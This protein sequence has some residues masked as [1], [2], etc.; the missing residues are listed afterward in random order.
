[1][2]HRTPALPLLAALMTSL[3]VGA[4]SAA[5]PDLFADRVAPLLRR[6]AS[7]HNAEKKRGGLDLTTRD[8]LLA[9]GDTGP[10]AKPGAADNSLLIWMVGGPEAKMPKQ[11]PKLT[12]D[13]FA[14]LRRW[15]DAGA[16]WPKDVAVTAD[17]PAADGEEWWSLRPV[18]RPAVPAVKDVAW[19]RNPIDAFLL[20]AMEQKGLRPS[21]P[22]DKTTLIRR[23]TFDLIG[24]PPTPEEI[25]VFL[26]DDSP[27]AYEKVVDR[28]LASP[29]YGERWARHWLDV[30]HYADTH[31][32]DK[33]KRRDH[34]WPYRDYVIR[35]FND[36]MPYKRFIQEQLAGDVLF[37]GDPDGVTATGFV[38]AGPWDFVG[39]VE[40]REGTVDKEKTRV[41][42]R[43]DMVINAVS[44]FDSMTV[45]CARCHDHKF[46]PIP[47]KD[48]YRL[49][50]VFAGVERGDRP[51]L[52]KD[53]LA[54]RTEL[55]ARRKQIADER[56]GF[57]KK[58]AD[59]SSPDLTRLDGE[60]KKAREDLAALPLPADAPSPTNGWHSGIEAKPDAVKWVQVD[61]GKSVAIDAVRLIPARPTD[62]PDTPGFGFPVRF[63][64]DASDDPSF[65]TAVGVAD[66]MKEDYA[67]PGDDPV[68][69]R[70]AALKARFVR[71]TATR[72]WKRTG[73]Y[74]F[75]LAELEVDSG[76]KN[77]A[78]V[79]TVTS[80]DS[81]E[82]GRWGRRNLVDGYDSRAA[83]PDFSD[84]KTP[85]ALKRR[86]ELQERIQR[87]EK[88]RQAA[89]EALLDAA[90]RDGLART[91]ADLAA[92]DRDLA[93]LAKT[94]LVYAVAPIP[95]RPIFVLHRGDVEQKREQVT[96]GALSCV[97]E[98][99][100]DFKDVKENDEGSRRAALARWVADNRNPLT[101]RSIV[102][103]VWHYHFGRGIVDTPSDLGRNGS[104][105]T[106]PELLD[107]LA[108]EFRDGGGSFK[109]LHRLIVTSAAY[110]QSSADNPEA[111]KIDADDR[112]LWRMTRQRLDAEEVRDSVLA[113]SGKLDLT[114]GGPGFELF[115]FKDD[116]SPV[117]D[118]TAVENIND[119]ANWRR[120]VYRFT[121]RSVPNPFLESLDCADPNINTPVRNTTLTALQALALLNDP[122][123]LKQADCFAERLQKISDDPARQAEAA[124]RLA[125]GRPPTAEERDALVDYAKKHGLAKACRVLFNANEFVF[126]D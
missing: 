30:A 61:L 89:I 117:Y 79:A 93:E 7:C 123:A 2:P 109:K 126:I 120:T 99:D 17:K 34:A 58:A 12:A 103:R 53:A 57:L 83:L 38:V 85:E 54:R 106:H 69:F 60:L 104:R 9:G 22:A 46:D 28:L 47:Q 27:D 119:P 39:H 43:D 24:L 96:P 41:L 94:N 81:I 13:E 78:R 100:A 55:E 118:H 116:H 5:E 108:V 33:D 101:W 23:V 97:K 105:P 32:Y 80:L 35:A 73:D 112:F 74:V 107:W 86:A 113:V 125:F 3:G 37:P 77:A 44:T 45:H 36:D 121:V 6:C 110:R 90:T 63:R 114:M 70:P 87:V 111:A 51:Y 64:V 11:G 20:A 4:V 8:R 25:E 19:A 124:Y 42:D 10:A 16:P 122:F 84:P 14:D 26:K 66:Q 75:A 29:R 76:G 18:T 72:L 67:N 15:I 68:V 59:V 50:A 91:A 31:G 98:L 62:F 95:P 88:D 56:A 52:S 48:Y 65:T 40:L 82:A 1:M 21:P 92:V 71:V 49:Q 115:R 102:N